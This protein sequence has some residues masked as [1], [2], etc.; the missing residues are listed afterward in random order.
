MA[1]AATVTQTPAFEPTVQRQYQFT[2]K[3]LSIGEHSSRA[4]YR[5]RAREEKTAV[6]WGQ[7]KLL[8]SE[9]EL[10]TIYWDPKV[11]P[12]PLCVYAGAAPGIHIPLL[13]QM[14]PAFTFHLYDPSKFAITPT[15]KIQTFN[16]YFTDAVAKRYAGR[17]DVFFISDIR[18]TDY[19]LLR[20]EALKK[21]GITKFDVND[22]PIGPFDLIKEAFRESELKT[23]DQIWGD[24]LMQ[25]QWVLT[26]NPEHVLLKFRLPY[27][28][29]GVDRSV[30]YLKGVVYWQ[31]WSP[32]TSTE[33]RLKPLRNAQGRYE[34]ANWSI[35]E[36][37]QWNF[38]HNTVEREQTFYQNIFT[39]TSDPIDFPELTNDYDSVA[40]AFVLRSYLEK[41]GVTNPE[42]LYAQVKKFSRIITWSINKYIGDGKVPRTLEQL[43]ASP[44]KYVPDAFRAKQGKRPVAPVRHTV[45]DVNP[46]W[47]KPP[48]PTVVPVAPPADLTVVPVITPQTPARPVP[49]SPIITTVTAPTVIIPTT[50][51]IT[52]VPVA[53]PV[54]VPVAP[55][56]TV[57]PITVPPITVPPITVPPVAGATRVVPTVPRSPVVPVSRKSVV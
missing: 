28:L 34:L 23:E 56:I 9:I 13:A 17:N 6:H 46:T 51:P 30:Q 18:T 15:E 53:P 35:L 5:R 7:R 16:E 57:P 43:R 41:F 39:G 44:V 20:R 55:P 40:E 25:Q 37:E 52:A 11:I 47:R 2:I 21:R 54:T 27:V 1:T 50:P 49:R 45:I 31:I 3:N 22:E 4:P 42:T 36:Y 38:H 33:T 14:F 32:Q 19:K 48:T 26:M 12:N 29:D 24:M 8:L 10:F